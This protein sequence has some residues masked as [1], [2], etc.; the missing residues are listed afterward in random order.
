MPVPVLAEPGDLAGGDLQRGE[1]GG[2]AV[3]DVVVGALLGMTGLHRQR[4]LWVRFK[5]WISGTSRPHTA[6]PRSPAALR[7]SPT[8]SVTLASSSGSV[9]N[10]NVSA[11]HGFTPYSVHTAATVAWSIPRRG[12]SSRRR[13]VR[14]SQTLRR[15]RQRGR[16][17]RGPV[18]RPGPAR[19]PVS[20]TAHPASDYGVAGPATDSPSDATPRPVPAISWF[21]TP[22]AASNTIRARCA[23]AA[24]PVADRVKR[25]SS[26]LSPARKANGSAVMTR[27]KLLQRMALPVVQ[28]IWSPTIQAWRPRVGCA[29]D[30]YA[31]G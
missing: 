12:A 21:A 13:P 15:R 23:A 2:G 19:R 20:D 4:L 25:S 27:R 16:D 11:F 6:R 26:V 9:E 29:H 8:M 28:I 3:P 17:D 5:A 31:H 14:H 24:A 10:L 22:S 18:H 7:Y 30:R 1:Q